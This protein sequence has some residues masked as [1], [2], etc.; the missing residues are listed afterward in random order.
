[1]SDG[2]IDEPTEA[3]QD[4]SGIAVNNPDWSW[5]REKA[6]EFAVQARVPNAGGDEIVTVAKTFEVYLTGKI[7]SPSVLEAIETVREYLSQNGLNL[8]SYTVL[9]EYL[10]DLAALVGNND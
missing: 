5:K 2:I 1:M 3:F 8:Q 9:D 4:D 6:L 7:E 10:V